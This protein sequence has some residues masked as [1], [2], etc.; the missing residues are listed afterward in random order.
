MELP[1][2]IKG[3][4]FDLDGT[5]FDSLGL[6]AEIDRRFLLVRGIEVPPDYMASIGAMEYRQTAE[7]TIARF[8][9][10]ETPESLMAEWTDMAVAAYAQTL[11]PKPHIAALVRRLFARGVKLA[12]AT[13]ATPDMCVPALKNNGLFDMFSA[14]VTTS[15]IGKGKAFADV[16]LRAAELI[17]IL[18]NV[19]AVFEDNHTALLTAKS[20]G[21]FTVGVFDA[22]C[23]KYW[24]LIRAHAD[25]YI[26]DA[27]E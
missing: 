6:W 2:H 1:E 16:Y 7:Y 15:E 11:K 21:F 12:V 3:A 18:P 22:H 24:D 10:D 9:L 19:C 27:D 26:T 4:I 23:G 8:D 13:S 14:I 20:A 17:G 5:L 25:M